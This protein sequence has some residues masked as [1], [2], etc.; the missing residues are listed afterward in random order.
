MK[1][2]L[3]LAREAYDEGEV[4][5]GCVIVLK[6]KVIGAGRN[7]REQSRSPLGHAEV[8]AIDAACRNI[9]DW[10]LSE[11]VMY[12]TLEPCAM[13]AGAIMNA[14]IGTVVFGAPDPN[15]GACGGVINIFEEPFG[16]KPAL[17]GGIMEKECGN[18]ITDFFAN[19]RKT[20][21]KH[22]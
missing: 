3:S 18:L 1:M 12:V 13:C 6:D 8:T 16:Y 14:R 10:R 20:G 7:T 5:V 4:P 11:A 2:A 21:E 9:S 22:C 15:Y 17:Y 19:V